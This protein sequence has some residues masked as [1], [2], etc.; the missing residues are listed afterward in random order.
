MKWS[1]KSN[2]CPQCKAKFTMLDIPGRAR[3]KRVKPATRTDDFD[4]LHEMFIIVATYLRSPRFR[5]AFARSTLT[6]GEANIFLFRF[7]RHYIA[8]LAHTVN[9]D[10]IRD[11]DLDIINAQRAMVSLSVEVQERMDIT[12]V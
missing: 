10:H 9:Y 8:R 4:D 1:D 6:L 12:S 5:H 3:R 11:S 2:E 7:V